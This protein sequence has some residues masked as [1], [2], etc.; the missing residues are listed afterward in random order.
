VIK[1]G[2]GWLLALVGV[3]SLAGSMFLAYTWL[4]GEAVDIR[5]VPFM[6]FSGSFVT[7]FLCWGSFRMLHHAP[8]DHSGPTG[9]EVISTAP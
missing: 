4:M 7:V 1:R 5:G 3:A 8:D 9:L 2:L 6:V